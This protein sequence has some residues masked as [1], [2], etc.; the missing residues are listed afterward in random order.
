MIIGDHDIGHEPRPQ[1]RLRRLPI[2]RGGDCGSP[3]LRAGFAGLREC[4]RHCRARERS[5]RR[6]AGAGLERAKRRVAEQRRALRSA[7]R[8]RT[9]SR[10]RAAS[11]GSIHVR[12]RGSGARR[13]TG[14]V[15]SRHAVGRGR[16]PREFTK[17]FLLLRFR[18]AGPGVP[19]FDVELAGTAPA[20]DEHTALLR[21]FHR[22]GHK[23]LHRRLSSRRSERTAH[24]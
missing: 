19:D 24:R 18:N 20:T 11:A 1:R 10:G 17:N 3:S 6:V 15:P 9:A 2:R 16:E 13:W 12:A 7:L 4:A 8:R 21:I 5:F 22:V 23:V 14:P